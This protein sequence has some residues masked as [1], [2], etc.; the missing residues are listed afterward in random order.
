MTT[1]TETQLSDLIELAFDRAVDLD[2]ERTP[3]PSDRNK[4]SD[5][6]WAIYRALV[7]MRTETIG[8]AVR[9]ARTSVVPNDNAEETIGGWRCYSGAGCI[10]AFN[11]G[12]HA[13]RDSA[14]RCIAQDRQRRRAAASA[15]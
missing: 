12:K 15:Q 13:T 5:S 14:E 4:R 7:T 2:A 6:A 11:R 1:L 3:Y 9:A 8:A 10:L